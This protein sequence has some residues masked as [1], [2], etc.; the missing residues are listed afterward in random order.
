MSLLSAPTA[1][2]ASECA[3][4]M[5]VSANWICQAITEGKPAPGGARVKLEAETIRGTRRHTYRIYADRFDAFLVAMGRTRLLGSASAPAPAP[6]VEKK[7]QAK[8]ALASRHK[9]PS[10]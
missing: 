5:G 9:R 10:P 2:R 6:R 8:A 1:L 3:H 4:F 7:R